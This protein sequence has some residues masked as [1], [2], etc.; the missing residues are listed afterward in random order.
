M[1][2][3]AACDILPWF[4]SVDRADHTFGQATISWSIR[5]RLVRGQLFCNALFSEIDLMKVMFALSAVISVLFMGNPPARAGALARY[6][7][8][9]GAD[10]PAVSKPTMS[11]T[12]D[13]IT[14]ID[15]FVGE[16]VTLNG[17]FNVAATEGLSSATGLV[18]Y[19]VG[20][21]T[22]SV[23]ANGDAASRKPNAAFGAGLAS[24]R[25]DVQA[26]LIDIW[27]FT[28]P[29]GV[30][31]I[32]AN[33]SFRVSAN[34]AAG[35]QGATGDLFITNDEVGYSA[36]AYLQI[37][38]D[39]IPAGPH[40]GTSGGQFNYWAYQQRRLAP[41]ASFESVVDQPLTTNTIPVVIEATRNA[42]LVR[43]DLTAVAEGSVEARDHNNFASG[44]AFAISD[45]S[46]TL[47]WG[48]ISSVVDA[49]TGLPV[50]DWTLTSESGFDWT[51][52][53]VIPEP[54]A[55]ALALVALGALAVSRRMVRRQSTNHR[56]HSHHNN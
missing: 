19:K 7:L 31:K 33:A 42:M 14:G 50:A 15:P 43:W 20:K 35:G 3:L 21:G 51:Q 28:F 56:S 37:D 29:A 16:N 12:T 22:I 54:T 41:G 44:T 46:H 9:A 10:D 40:S 36:T 18:T 47:R 48:G 25:S 39:G 4:A 23:Y 27:V 53:A 26:A 52:P 17:N 11:N 34:L 13:S 24:F 45:A 32:K 6:D 5:E 2:Q 38:G 1:T 30:N 49:D 55:S 8:D